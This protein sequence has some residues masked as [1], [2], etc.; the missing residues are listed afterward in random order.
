MDWGD[1]VVDGAGEA[2]ATTRLEI[3]RE[4]VMMP[5][6]MVGRRGL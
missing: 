1:S 5:S 6:L 2:R 4:A 3:G